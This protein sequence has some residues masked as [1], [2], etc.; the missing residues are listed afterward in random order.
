M[1]AEPT[2]LVT[3][4][5]GQADELLA[6]LTRLGVRATHLPMLELEAIEP[7]APSDHQCVLD[8]DRY[9]HVIFVSA[10]AARFGMA[11]VED[12]WPQL[13]D[14]QRYWAVGVSTAEALERFHVSAMYPQTMNSEGLLELMATQEMTDQRVLLVKG[15]GG[16][17]LIEES[18]TARGASVD[19]LRCY[20]RGPVDYDMSTLQSL[21]ENPPDLVLVSSGEGLDCL[22]RLLQPREHTNLTQT[23]LIVPSQRVA[24]QASE[25][26]WHHIICAS[27]AADAAMLASTKDWLEAHLEEIQH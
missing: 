27:S 26:G 12:Y 17:S 24:T 22:N 14:G 3:R 1:V 10:N 21:R 13:P 25:S 6:A 18:L 23:A 5:A 9:A 19:S 7:L 4:P 16:R 8:F 11:C 15:E 2:V 20:R